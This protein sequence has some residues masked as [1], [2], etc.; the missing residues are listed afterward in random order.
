MVVAVAFDILQFIGHM[1][2]GKH[3]NS[4]WL[5]IGTGQV[6]NTKAALQGPLLTQ[7]DYYMSMSASCPD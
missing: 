4:L 7:S 2:V 5:S 6:C 1:L 3:C